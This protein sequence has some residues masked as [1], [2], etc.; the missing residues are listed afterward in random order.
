MTDDHTTGGFQQSADE[1]DRT[2]QRFSYDSSEPQSVG[3]AI[4]RALASV[5][6]VDALSL[7]PRLYDVIDA[8]ALERLLGE[9]KTG[10]ALTV[11]FEFGQHLVTITND[12]ELI[13]QPSGGPE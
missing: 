7:E 10:S 9:T 1:T 5:T 3:L 6:D 4:I 11:S 13:V 12:D 2:T 8:D